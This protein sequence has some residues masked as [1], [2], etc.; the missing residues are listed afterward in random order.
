MAF[1]STVCY[2]FY[3]KGILLAQQEETI[4]KGFY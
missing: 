1:A 3:E 2:N 4:P